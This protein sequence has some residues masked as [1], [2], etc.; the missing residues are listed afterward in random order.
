M[1]TASFTPSEK[2]PEIT[3]LLET[4][5]GRSTSIGATKCIDPPLGCGQ[6]ITGF[7]DALSSKE[8][9][10]SG[11]CQ[12]CQDKVFAPEADCDCFSCQK[13]AKTLTKQVDNAKTALS[14]GLKV[15]NFTKAFGKIITLDIDDIT[16]RGVYD[17]VTTSRSGNQHRFYYVQ[18]TVDNPEQFAIDQGS[19]LRRERAS[20]LR[21]DN[22]DT[23]AYL[24]FETESGG[25]SLRKWLATLPEHI[26]KLVEEVTEVN[27]DGYKVA[28][29]WF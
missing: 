4:L 22:G 19:D 16:T 23:L 6:P 21:Y 25:G 18:G 24:T 14:K 15:F 10:I 11:F 1:S 20:K 7:K 26:Q 8:Y 13:Y 5:S 3:D 28:E 12:A 2:S 9:S 17:F 27:D 29:D